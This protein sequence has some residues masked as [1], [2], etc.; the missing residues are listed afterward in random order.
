MTYVLPS[1]CPRSNMA[2]RARPLGFHLVDNLV[3]WLR[4][5]WHRRAIIRQLQRLDDRLLRD[6]GINRNEIEAFTDAML[7]A[8][9]QSQQA[10]ARR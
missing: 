10:A 1:G 2:R 7:T 8:H 3:H 4:S 5:K 6:I 9:R